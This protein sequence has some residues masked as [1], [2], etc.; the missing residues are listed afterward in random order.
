M[1]KDEFLSRMERVLNAL[2][3]HERIDILSDYVE[4]FRAGE[5]AGKTAE[6]IAAALGSPE[7]LARTFL[8]E[9]GAAGEKAPEASLPAQPVLP[10]M[11]QIQQGIPANP[12][13]APPPAA[14]VPP[15]PHPPAPPSPPVQMVY[16]PQK[17]KG[18]TTV[19]TIVVILVSV[20][21]ILP[22]AVGIISGL[23]AV[24]GLALGFLVAAVALFVGGIPLMVK[25]L[26]GRS[27]ICMAVAF[28]AL[29]VLLICATIALVKGIVWLITR[30][31]RL[32]TRICREGRWPDPE[33]KGAV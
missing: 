28:L 29:S 27:V 5:E 7:E 14:P 13:S 6:E 1:T 23:L 18:D 16:A 10:E 19:A 4:H 11:P 22:T 25:P 31:V 12:M 2:P 8:E 17:P 33:P 15:A 30:Y 32:C 20:L 24:P 26:A 21:V 9:R 3:P